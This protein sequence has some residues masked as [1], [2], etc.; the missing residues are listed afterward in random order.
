MAGLF[1]GHVFQGMGLDEEATAPSPDDAPKANEGRAK[2]GT[3]TDMRDRAPITS[4][5]L[6]QPEVASTTT[7]MPYA[8]IGGGVL[9]AGGLIWMATSGG[10]KANRRT[11]SRRRYTR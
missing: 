1:S 2:G 8:L 9:L 3:F 6:V 7:W 11:R 10:M 5:P 4:L